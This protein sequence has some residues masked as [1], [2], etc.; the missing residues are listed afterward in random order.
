MIE[1]LKAL[2]AK[3]REQITYIIFGFMT[4]F[5]NWATY[6]A[7][8]FIPWFASK[9][10]SV[11]L[12]GREY[13][14]GYLLANAIAFVVAVIFA[15]IVNRR[16]VFRSTTT[17]FRAILS[18]FFRFVSTRLL[19]FAIEE[20]LLWVFVDKL[21]GTSGVAFISEHAEF[22]SKIPVAAV[23]AVLNYLFGKFLVFR[24]KRSP[25]EPESAPEAEGSE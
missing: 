3:Y 17:G 22:L 24:K 23:N 20:V 6:Y 21:F 5:V 19:S 12:F 7:L 4:T 16:F 9:E 15:F 13:P 10:T 2:Y 14:F 11:S 8:M 1:K 18:E 25:A